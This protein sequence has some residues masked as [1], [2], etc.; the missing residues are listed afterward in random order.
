M[1]KDLIGYFSCD[2]ETGAPVWDE[3]C[4]CGDNIFSV[5]GTGTVG[6]PIKFADT[7]VSAEPVAHRLLR[8]N[9]DGEWV[10]DAKHWVNG[11]PPPELIR[12]CWQT[13]ELYRIE[14]AYAAPVAAQPDV[15]QQTLDDVMAGI[16]ARDAEI[17]ALRKEIE[18]LKA[19]I[20]AEPVAVSKGWKLVPIEPT[21]AMLLA[22]YSDV[23]DTEIWWS[24]MLN[25]AP[26]GPVAT[27]APAFSVGVRGVGVI[28]DNPSALAVYFNAAPNDDDIRA[29]HEIVSAAQVATTSP[30]LAQGEAR[31]NKGITRGKDGNLA[32]KDGPEVAA[33][34]SA[35]A[36]PPEKPLPDLM[37]ASYH[38]AIGWNECRKAMIAAQAQ[39]PV[40][41]ADQ[42]RDAAQMIEPS[43]N[44]GELDEQEAFEAW[45]FN[46]TP[47]SA[48]FPTGR[49][50]L[51]DYECP[52]TDGA[53][54]GWQARAA[55]AQQDAYR[56]LA[57]SVREPA[58]GNGWRVHW[59][60][61][62]MRLMLPEGSRIH[63]HNIFRNGTMVI[64]IKTDAARKEQA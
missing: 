16:P 9:G 15:T 32:Q 1:S 45:A 61:E 60:N 12:D 50:S 51:G 26:A 19:T 35:P 7:P 57:G 3:G 28:D 17:A 43:G 2:P 25:A 44:S 38:E 21:D 47:N 56:K 62:S 53:W 52:E 31:M 54:H 14:V 30:A 34:S 27:P 55:L 24:L 63:Y 39:Q 64:T 10:H 23:H 11:W 13:P 46:D 41:G 6:R 8:R 33:Q 58:N 29:L 5:E 22:G 59:W 4:V 48:N 18:T 20:G 36:I 37:M 49:N 40:S 42:L